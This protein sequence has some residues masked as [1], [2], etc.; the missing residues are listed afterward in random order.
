[1]GLKDFGN[2]GTDGTQVAIAS[3]PFRLSFVPQISTP[4]AIPSLE[5][6]DQPEDFTDVLIDAL[7]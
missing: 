1:M 3:Y 6:G 2:F 5:D 4:A 7:D